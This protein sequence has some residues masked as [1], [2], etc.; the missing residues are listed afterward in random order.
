MLSTLDMQSDT[1]LKDYTPNEMI[2]TDDRIN[3]TA[4]NNIPW[5]TP[6]SMQRRPWNI[7]AESIYGW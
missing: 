2:Q 6:Q 4:I 5:K 3:N 1:L 7:E